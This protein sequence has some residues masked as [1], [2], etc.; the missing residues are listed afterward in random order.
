MSGIEYLIFA[1]LAV[2]TGLLFLFLPVSSPQRRPNFALATFQQYR[3][4]LVIVCF[5]WAALMFAVWV[6]FI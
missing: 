3:R 6:G 2:L 4:L 5:S 1:I